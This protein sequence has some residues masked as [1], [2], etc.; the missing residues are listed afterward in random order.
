MMTNNH[1][2]ACH[3]ENCPGIERHV[4]PLT[5]TTPCAD[6]ELH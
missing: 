5:A 2:A 1:K 4:P 3:Q 6:N